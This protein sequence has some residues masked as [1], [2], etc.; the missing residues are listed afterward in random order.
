MVPGLCNDCPSGKSNMLMY[1]STEYWWNDTDRGKLKSLEEN[2]SQ[3]YF[4]HHKSDMD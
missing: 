4:V 1:M 3:Y 2:L